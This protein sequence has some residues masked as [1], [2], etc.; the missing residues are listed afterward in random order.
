[1]GEGQAL[2]PQLTISR[3]SRLRVRF[4]MVR[5]LDGARLEKKS[6][7]YS[8]CS[9]GNGSGGGGSVRKLFI[10]SSHSEILMELVNPECDERYY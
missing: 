7:L 9:G 5:A 10:G 2:V 6:E 1:M 4:A 3:S 8:T